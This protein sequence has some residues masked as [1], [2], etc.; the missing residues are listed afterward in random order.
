MATLNADRGRIEPIEPLLQL[1][2]ERNDLDGIDFVMGE[3]CHLNPN[4][5]ET[6]DHVSKSLGGLLAMFDRFASR[7]FSEHTEARWNAL[8]AAIHNTARH[9]NR[10]QALSTLDQ[11]LLIEQPK[12]RLELVRTLLESNCNQGVKLLTCYA[13][14]DL[15]PSVRAAATEALSYFNPALYRSELIDGL[16]Y[17]WPEVAMH[18]A[19]ALTRLNDEAAAMEIVELLKKSDPRIP[20]RNQDGHYVKKELVAINHMKNCTLCHADSQSKFDHGRGVIPKWGQPLR[21]QYYLPLNEAAVRA[22][23]TYLRQDFSAI[24]RVKNSDPWPE[25]QRFDYVVQARPISK[26]LALNLQEEFKRRPDEYRA[27]VHGTL[28][29]LTGEKANEPTFKAW[30]KIVAAKYESAVNG[31]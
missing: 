12:L 23:I 18:S 5:A 20:E 26:E 30:Q 27:I 8:K 15:D 31:N 21:E 16:R 28:V 3:A 11:M 14:Y 9:K 19:E 7:D 2:P 17:P 29:S 25:N 10:A 4:D 6:L 22:D 24:Q 1:L 13:K